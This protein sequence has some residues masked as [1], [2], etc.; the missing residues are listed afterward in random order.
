AHPQCRVV[1]EYGPTETTVMSN[2]GEPMVPS[3]NITVG[4]PLRGFDEVVLDQ[5][6]HPVPDGVVGE[7]YISGDALARGYHRKFA[8]TAERFVADPFGLPG[9]RMYRTGDLVRRRRGRALEYVGRS[10]FQVKVRGFRIE[11]GEIDKVVQSCPQVENAVTVARAGPSGTTMITTYVVPAGGS[12]LSTAELTQYAASRV[13]S[14]MVPA[15]FVLL[16]ELPVT[17]SGKVDRAALPAPLFDARSDN[18]RPPEGAEEL[19]LAEIFA[20]VLGAETVGAGDDF[21]ELGGN[22]LIATKLIARVNAAEAVDFGVRTLFEAPTVE[23]L[24]LQVR[25]AKSSGVDPSRSKRPILQAHSHRDKIPVSPAQRRLWFVNQFDTSSP[26]YNIPMVVRLSGALD[27]AALQLAMGDV[28]D[29]H[30]SLRT[31]YPASVDGPHQVV[32]PSERVTS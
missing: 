19:L 11:L 25:G 3:E 10:D 22:S 8:L 23:S 17:P 26:A 29:R 12:A 4:G 13:P 24:A 32:V 15:A 9:R 14:Y 20:D 2:I 18:F 21:F 31:V 5:R 27:V 1:N 6:L 7:L 16:D 30:E 28:V